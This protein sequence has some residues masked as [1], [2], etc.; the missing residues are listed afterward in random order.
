MCPVV[1]VNNP[2][3]DKPYPTSLMVQDTNGKTIAQVPTDA[4]GNFRIPLAPGKY[5]LIP[6][7]PNG[8]APPSAQPIEFT[9]NAGQFTPVTITYDSGIR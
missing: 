6:D 7:D 4:N 8:G 2:C 5:T 3:P 1:Q 9:V